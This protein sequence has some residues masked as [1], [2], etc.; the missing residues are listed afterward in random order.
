M[1]QYL[2][3][4]LQLAPEPFLQMFLTQVL[5]LERDW[6]LGIIPATHTAV[7]GLP[8]GSLGLGKHDQAAKE[9]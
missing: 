7:P 5:R 9:R 3:V 8:L 6:G 2:V 1:G 4:I